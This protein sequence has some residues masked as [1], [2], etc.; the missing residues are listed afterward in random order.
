V[1]GLLPA[2]PDASGHSAAPWYGIPH[3]GA[4]ILVFLMLMYAALLYVRGVVW[5]L[6]PIMTKK[7]IKRLAGY[8][9]Y[10]QE[11]TKVREELYKDY[12]KQLN[13]D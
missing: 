2:S 6:W 4:Y 13:F 7:E 10:V 1:E 3:A 5:R 12:F 9:V 8:G 11:L